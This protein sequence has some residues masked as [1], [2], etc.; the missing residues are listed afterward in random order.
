MLETTDVLKELQEI[1]YLFK[2]SRNS[3]LVDLHHCTT[4]TTVCAQ[5]FISCLPLLFLP[6]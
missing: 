3:V 1:K 6:Q 2:A 4:T 5:C